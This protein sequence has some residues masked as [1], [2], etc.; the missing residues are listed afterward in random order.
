VFALRPR[1]RSRPRARLWHPRRLGTR[2]N[3]CSHTPR[4]LL[5]SSYTSSDGG[6]SGIRSC[7][8]GPGQHV[9][10]PAAD[11]VE[12]NPPAWILAA[13]ATCLPATVA[14]AAVFGSVGTQWAIA[15][16]FIGLFAFLFLCGIWFVRVD[17]VGLAGAFVLAL[18]GS[19]LLT[20]ALLA[21]TTLADH[22]ELT[23][24]QPTTTAPPTTRR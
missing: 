10:V 23:P 20:G 21:F 13:S 24:P 19:C 15:A 9:L 8:S 4:T 5:D 18:V 17:F 12:R 1:A 6:A 2:P 14:A 7:V 22:I 11:P 3:N 16:I